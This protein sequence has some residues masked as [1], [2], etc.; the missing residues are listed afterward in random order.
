[1]GGE[2]RIGSNEDGMEER[3]VTVDGHEFLLVRTETEWHVY[4][5]NA[6]DDC[7]GELGALSWIYFADA[8][9][10]TGLSIVNVDLAD[11][12]R[13]EELLSRVAVAAGLSL[14]PLRYVGRPGADA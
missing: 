5:E 1:M 11:P 10:T 9:T 6:P 7:H 8:T 13:K 3:R 14:R 4:W 12:D 2:V